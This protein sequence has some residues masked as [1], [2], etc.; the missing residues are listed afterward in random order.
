MV[1]SYLFLE[2]GDFLSCSH[3]FVGTA[4]GVHCKHCGLT[5]RP[6][7]YLKY[8]HPETQPQDKSKQRRR[9]KAAQ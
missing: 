1:F 7:E 5:M 3:E 8:I 2:R 4:Q 6:S 9:K